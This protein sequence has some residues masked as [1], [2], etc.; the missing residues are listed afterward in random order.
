MAEKE[1]WKWVVGYEGRYQV[2][3]LG[4]VRSWINTQANKQET[5]KIL[6]CFLR[7]GYPSFDF[8][9]NGKQKNFYVH[10]L[11]AL[12]FIP[13]PENKKEVNHIN[14]IKTD[15]RAINLEWVT[16]KE[17]I[18]H[19]WNTGLSS[20]ANYSSEKHYL[21]KFT[22]KQAKQIRAEYIF[23][24]RTHG[25][26]ALAKKY[27]VCHATILKIVKNQSYTNITEQTKQEE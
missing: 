16:P 22:N 7:R 23:G 10:R 8:F 26:T 17:N 18:R 2:S 6:K 11:V 3:N 13:N 9:K 15:N 4:R 19:A 21:A 5:P 27:G 12:N 20:V 1:I 25:T 24:S 14:G